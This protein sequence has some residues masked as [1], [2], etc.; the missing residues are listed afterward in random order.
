[1]IEWQV[2]NWHEIEIGFQRVVDPI[3]AEP[4]KA[5]VNAIR[6]INQSN[7]LFGNHQQSLANHPKISQAGG[8]EQTAQWTGL[9]K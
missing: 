3:Q 9:D 8:Q 6:T 1:M 7:F 2:E 5:F 4:E